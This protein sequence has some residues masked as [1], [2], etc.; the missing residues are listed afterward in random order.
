[1][2]PRRPP[3]EARRI[4]ASDP[5]CPRPRFFTAA[6]LS[7][8]VLI[9]CSRKSPMALS[10]AYCT[11]CLDSDSST[12]LFCS[13]ISGFR[14]RGGRHFSVL[15]VFCTPFSQRIPPARDLSGCYAQAGFSP[16]PRWASASLR[17]DPPEADPGPNPRRSK[18][19]RPA[20]AKW[21]AAGRQAASGNAATPRS[22]PVWVC[23]A[24][25][26]HHPM[27]QGTRAAGAAASPLGRNF[28]A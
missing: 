9:P 3:R 12:F 24:Q 2:G 16:L 11:L 5:G 7:F 21:C 28:L 19:L 8:F 14:L 13:M 22:L 23:R 20:W 6:N 10:K 18:R 26:D 27:Q 25:I 4:S 17:A 15:R 1:M